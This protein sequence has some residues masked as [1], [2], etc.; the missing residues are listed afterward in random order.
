M[1]E[2]QVD[3]VH[4]SLSIA[5][6]FL[7]PDSF[8]QSH[9]LRSRLEYFWLSCDLRIAYVE[10]CKIM[11]VQGHYRCAVCQESRVEDFART[12]ARQR[13]KP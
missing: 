5:K 3:D 7:A 12:T 1:A 4:L 10:E 13:N 2:S 9:F 8:S 11:S 6:E